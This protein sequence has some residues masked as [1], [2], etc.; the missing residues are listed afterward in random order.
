MVPDKTHL[1]KGI[2]GNLAARDLRY[3]G[4]KLYFGSKDLKIRQGWGTPLQQEFE[5][6][7]R[8]WVH[9]GSTN[10]TLW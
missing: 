9:L 10:F 7:V 4:G 5:D 1:A 8:E 2:E 3:R 6:I